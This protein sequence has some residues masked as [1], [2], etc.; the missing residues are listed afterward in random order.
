M[1]AALEKT[2]QR[3]IADAYQ[4]GTSIDEIVKQFKCGRT[5]IDAIVRRFGLPRRNKRTP[6]IA[7]GTEV[8]YGNPN[9]PRRPPE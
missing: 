6:Q 5:T 4:A 2:T 8:D 3:D 1:T 7:P 9:R